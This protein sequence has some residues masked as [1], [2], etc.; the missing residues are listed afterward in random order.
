MPFIVIRKNKRAKYRFWSW[1]KGREWDD[2]PCW[3][4]N[5]KKYYATHPL[6]ATQYDNEHDAWV[7][8][9]RSIEYVID[10]M[11]FLLLNPEYLKNMENHHD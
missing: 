1:P 7:C 10:L 2:Y 3:G 6:Q 11:E 9:N 8:C 4:G 5:A